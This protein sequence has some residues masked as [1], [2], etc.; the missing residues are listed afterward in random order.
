MID[1]VFMMTKQNYESNCDNEDRIFNYFQIH[2]K[3]VRSILPPKTYIK[4]HMLRSK[5]R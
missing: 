5:R 4:V 1:N 2:P 3:F